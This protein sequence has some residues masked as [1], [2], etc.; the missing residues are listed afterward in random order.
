MQARKS[1]N[2][3]VSTYLSQ[4]DGTQK[5]IVLKLREIVLATDPSITEDIKW[6]SCLTFMYNDKN[7]VQTVVGKKHTTFIFFDGIK[8]K[9]PHKLLFGDG[10]TVRSAR[11]SDENI[12]T[13]AIQD[14]VRQE[15][16]LHK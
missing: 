7:I 1:K 6:K 12:N 3:R 8:L 9:D 14:L 15:I 5:P 4:L 2:A 16:S 11:F 13:T 10:K